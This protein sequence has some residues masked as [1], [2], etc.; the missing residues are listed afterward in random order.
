MVR[1]EKKHNI[2]IKT[3]ILRFLTVYGGIIKIEGTVLKN[4]VLSLGVLFDKNLAFLEYI[5]VNQG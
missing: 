4:I 3:D 5:T 1:H 2:W